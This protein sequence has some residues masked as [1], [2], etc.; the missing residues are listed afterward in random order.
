MAIQYA[1]EAFCVMTGYRHE[2]LVGASL[3]GLWGPNTDRRELVRMR[4][5]AAAGWAARGEVVAYRSDG[6]RFVLG[7]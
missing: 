4:R 1:N 2:E 3:R 6:T 7:W 5:A